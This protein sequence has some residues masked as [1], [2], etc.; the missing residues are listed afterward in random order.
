M[1]GGCARDWLASKA[2]EQVLGR[3]RRPQSTMQ[4]ALYAHYVILADLEEIR[5]CVVDIS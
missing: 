5:F 2:S 3:G 4:A 1:S